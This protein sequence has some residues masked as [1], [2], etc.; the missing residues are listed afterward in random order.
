MAKG[1]GFVAIQKSI[2]AKEGVPEKSASPA[3]KA[4]NPS[5]KKVFPA[6]KK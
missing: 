5:A 1:K 2:A 6:K 3:A 4:V